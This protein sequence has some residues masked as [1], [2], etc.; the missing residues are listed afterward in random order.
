L[1]PE[2][3]RAVVRMHL[4][5]YERDEIAELLGWSEPKTRNLLYR[6]LA[7]LREILESWGIRPGGRSQ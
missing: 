4:A 2:S 6:G 7:D 5:G 1:L 3:R